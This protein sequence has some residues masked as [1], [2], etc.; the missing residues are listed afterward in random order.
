VPVTATPT[1]ELTDGSARGPADSARRQAGLKVIIPVMAVACGLTVA[2][3]YYSQPLLALMASTFHVS[4]GTAAIVVTATQ[5]GYA[6]GLAF[7]VPLGD[8][9]ENR[10]LACRTLVLTAIAL[11]V[12]AVA[13]D[14]ELFLVM[15]VAIGVTSVVVQILVPFAAQLAP[16][17]ERGK[18]VGRVMSGLLLGILLA[19]SLSSVTAAAWGW[20][21]IYLISAVVMIVLSAVLWRVLP[22]HPPAA[23]V[24]YG[25]L[26]RSAVQ[27]VRDEPILRRRAMGQAL[28][29]GAFSCFWTS[30]AYELID[31]HHLTQLRIAVFA[32]VGAA[33]AAAALV[34]GVLGDRGLSRLGRGVAIV[35]GAAAMVLAGFGSG[36]IILLAA[37]AVLL[38]LATQGNQV[39]SQRDIYALREDARARLNT[40]Y[41]TSSFIGGAVASAISGW[42]YETH[43][44]GAVTIFGAA[45]P[46]VAGAIWL[47]EI[48]WPPAPGRVPPAPVQVAAAAQA[49]APAQAPGSAADRG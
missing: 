45:L 46:L 22:Q 40:V 11:G 36:S 15:S 2:N 8:V 20:R 32:L 47:H 37:A 19:R 35:L 33:G 3:L 21:S 31:A 5:L 16:A 28:M 49:P 6:A 4:Q 30:I 43:G 38:D 26:L 17:D 9:L 25:R 24:R 23:A 14:F 34:A 12:A 42:L 48:I 13:P 39:L 18:Y 1:T 41:M 27:L 10:K 7:L 29:F 44:W